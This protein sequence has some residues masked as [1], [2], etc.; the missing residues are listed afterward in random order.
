MI[1]RVREGVQEKLRIF[2]LKVAKEGNKS[3]E[4]ITNIM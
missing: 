3:D 4:Q 2:S 1:F